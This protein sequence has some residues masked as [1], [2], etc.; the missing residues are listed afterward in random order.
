MVD[1]FT[2]AHLETFDNEADKLLYIPFFLTKLTV[3][4]IPQLF[5]G[6]GD[7]FVCL[8]C[9]TAA[10]TRANRDVGKS[11]QHIHAAPTTAAFSTE[12]PTGGGL[13]GPTKTISGDILQIYFCGARQGC[14]TFPG[15]LP[16]VLCEFFPDFPVEPSNREK[17]EK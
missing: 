4:S 12:N 3:V 13:R 14:T 17:A 9:H 10:L 7:V 15:F 8:N 5:V 6:L 2:S 1:L 11:H 16:E